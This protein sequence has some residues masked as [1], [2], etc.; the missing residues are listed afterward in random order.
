MLDKP[1]ELTP[2]K[3][4]LEGKLEYVIDEIE[5]GR[6]F[7]I[8]FTSIPV[9]ERKYNGLLKLRTNYPEKQEII[10]PIRGQI[11]KKLITNSS[12]TAPPPGQE[13]N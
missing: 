2:V 3:F 8:L 10:I 4:N 12:M 9:N 5:K 7:Q 11:E 1:L 13:K 6:Q